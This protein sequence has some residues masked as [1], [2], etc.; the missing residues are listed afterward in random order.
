MKLLFVS[1]SGGH[2]AQLMSL[3]PWW[4]DHERIWVTSDKPDAH[5]LLADEEVVFA[6]EPTTR[7]LTN[8]VRNFRLA[9]RTIKRERPDVVVSTGAGVAPPFFLAAAMQRVQRVYLEVYDRI[10]SATLSGRL[11]YP[12]SNRFLLQWEEQQ[13][14]YPKGIQVGRVL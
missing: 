2:L 7:S 5:S 9:W 11:C 13:R 8:L 12:L 10:E 3:R 6:H 1:S 14:L 4:H